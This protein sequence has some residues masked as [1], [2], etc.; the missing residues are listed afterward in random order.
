MNSTFE[1]TDYYTIQGWMV[2]EL[3]M[4]MTER[5][6]FALI[7]SYSRGDN[8]QFYG[9][10]TYL[11]S[12]LGITKR[13]MITTLRALCEKG[14]IERTEAISNGCSSYGYRAV[15]KMRI[16]QIPTQTDI[17]KEIVE[18]GEKISPSGEKIS[19]S[20]E[21]ISPSGEKISPSGEKISPTQ[22]TTFA[23]PTPPYIDNIYN[24]INNISKKEA[25]TNV[26][27]KKEA[28]EPLLA[29]T[30]TPTPYENFIKWIE[31]NAPYIHR[32]LT[33]PKEREFQELQKHYSSQRIAQTIA[34]LEN[35][36][37]LRKRYSNLYRTL[38]NWL[39][40]SDA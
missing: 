17:V 26:C 3:D 11:A 22:D 12:A 10:T 6:V 33:L 30:H 31:D 1:T 15:A 39:K 18:R 8:Q 28:D 4:T 32:N 36:K 20:G 25:H 35:R 2:Q 13:T 14:Y 21:K 38:I 27:A 16:G 19:P 7:Y 24:N 29:P 34:E 5:N 40:N 9:T 37:D 23:P